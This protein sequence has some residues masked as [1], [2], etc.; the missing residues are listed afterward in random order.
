MKL[1]FVVLIL[2]TATGF[3]SCGTA[4]TQP[5]ASARTPNDGWH[6]YTSPDKSFSAELPCE[7]KQT[8]VSDVSTP[9]YQYSCHAEGSDVLRAFVITVMK[10][11]LEIGKTHDEAAF[12]RSVKE[13]FTPNHHIVKMIPIKIDGGIGREIF[14]TNERDDMDNI[15]GRV[16]IFGGHR[17]E[18]AYLATDIKL[19]ES[20]EPDR[21][22]AGFKPL[23]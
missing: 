22:F 14:V 18:V 9:V 20:P 11:D 2:I 1:L 12:E 13:T 7:P 4:P 16:I 17:F 6:V 23:K 19:L 5:V 15:R 10:A 8:N 3:F 21:F